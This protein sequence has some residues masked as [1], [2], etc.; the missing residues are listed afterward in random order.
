[1]RVQCLH[2]FFC[3]WILAWV[4][5]TILSTPCS[6]DICVPAVVTNLWHFQPECDDRGHVSICPWLHGDAQHT[7]W[8]T[9]PMLQASRTK[10]ASTR[11]RRADRWQHRGKR[12]STFSRS[13][14]STRW[15]VSSWHTRWS[16][17]LDFLFFLGVPFIKGWGRG[18]SCTAALLW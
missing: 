3:F 1:M 15:S 7:D 13:L 8:R 16:V 4:E 14:S 9:R 12:S 5:G 2:F 11:T 6:A 18:G 17:N 10:C